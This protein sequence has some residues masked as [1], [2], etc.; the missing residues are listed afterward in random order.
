M[1]KISLMSKISVIIL[2]YNKSRLIDRAIRS[3]ENQIITPNINLEIIIVDDGSKDNPQKWLKKYKNQKSKKIFYL[4]KNKGVGYCSNF[5]LKNI[6]SKYYVRLDSDDYIS[7]FYIQICHDLLENNQKIGFVFSRW[8]LLPA[9]MRYQACH[10]GSST[11]YGYGSPR[12]SAPAKPRDV[13]SGS[14]DAPRPLHREAHA[15]IPLLY[16]PV[17]P[18]GGIPVAF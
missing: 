1:L 18:R 8:S 3:I 16:G 12:S 11:G 4:K 14:V 9:R 7:Q 13:R 6:S 15:A 17:L 5:A 2:N 10:S